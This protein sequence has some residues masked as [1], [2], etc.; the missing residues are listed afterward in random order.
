MSTDDAVRRLKLHDW[1]ASRGAQF[2]EDR[3]VLVPWKY[4][5]AQPGEGPEDRADSRSCDSGPQAGLADLSGYGRLELV[6]PDRHR[7]LGGLVTSAVADLEPGSGVYG[8]VTTIKGRVLSD[9][10]VSSFADRLFLLLPPGRSREVSEHLTKYIVADRVEVLPLQDLVP[11]ALLG[12]QLEQR[13]PPGVWPETPWGC[14]IAEIFGTQLP[15]SRHERFGCSALVA[16]VSS[17]ILEPVVSELTQRLDLELVGGSTLERL[18]VERGLPAFGIDFDEN[19][20]AQESGIEAVDFTKGCYLG[21]EVIARLHYRGQVPKVVR[22][23]VWSEENSDSSVENVR[24][25]DT[26]TFEGRKAGTVTTVAENQGF[27][28]VQ[29][30]AAELGTV[31]LIV[32]RPARP[33]EELRSQGTSSDDGSREEGARGEGVQQDS[34]G[35]A[36]TD[37]GTSSETGQPMATPARVVALQ[38]EGP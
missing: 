9:V 16:W 12:E 23:L 24:P 19:N 21:Q 14:Q 36:T 29:R 22:R 15:V 38:F 35:G 17:S 20:L 3:G 25:G 27:A 5:A 18:R 1:H 32:E 34:S 30:R 37:R 6:G 11:I 31:V 8:F 2:K 10:V 13:L 7:F 4:T 28:M 26:V 33:G